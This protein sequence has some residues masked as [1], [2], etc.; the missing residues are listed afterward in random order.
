MTLAFITLLSV[1]SMGC[2]RWILTQPV[3]AA[4]APVF[5]PSVAAIVPD[6]T[7]DHRGLV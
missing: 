1:V 7:F 4:L 3:Y 2:V 5:V 6:V